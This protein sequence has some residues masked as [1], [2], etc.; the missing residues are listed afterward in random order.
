MTKK[1][2]AQKKKKSSPSDGLTDIDR[3][4]LTGANLSLDPA[5]AGEMRE[6]IKA[7]TV[8]AKGSVQYY[9]LL[10]DDQWDASD[11]HD[12]V[13][14]FGATRLLY[15]Y[16]TRLKSAA[17]KSMASVQIKS[18]TIRAILDKIDGLQNLIFRLA[19]RRGE[20]K[21]IVKL[22][23]NGHFEASRHMKPDADEAPVPVLN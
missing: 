7:K 18:M 8:T 9:A 16:D 4:A 1:A 20:Q 2:E 5:K 21:P 17:N 23:S 12:D 11:E 22:L 3:L 14:I 13:R 10:D 15:D 19:E 6:L